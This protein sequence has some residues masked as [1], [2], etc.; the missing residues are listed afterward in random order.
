MK[1]DI[2]LILIVLFSAVIS[3]LMSCGLFKLIT[4]IFP[5]TFTWGKATIFWVA[6][7]ILYNLGFGRRE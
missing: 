2:E 1:D 7:V 5:V 3:W 4:M 6:L